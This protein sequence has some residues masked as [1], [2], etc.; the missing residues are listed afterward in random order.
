MKNYCYKHPLLLNFIS[1]ILLLTKQH[2]ER[3]Y[4]V[5]YSWENQP[6]M[7]FYMSRHSLCYERILHNMHDHQLFLYYE[8]CFI[9]SAVVNKSLN[10]KDL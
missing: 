8:Y 10:I 5:I 2:R 4:R 9:C 3:E 1:Y 6:H 7:D